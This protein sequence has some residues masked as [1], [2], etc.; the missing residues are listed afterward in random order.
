MSLKINVGC[1]DK[2]TEGWRNYDNSWSVRLAEKNFIT[3]FIIK[4]GILSESQQKFISYAK[5]ENILWANVSKNIPEKDSTVDVVYSCHMV[6]HL[7]KEDAILFLKESYRVLKMG[8]IIRVVVPNLKQQV[9]S[10]IKK[11]DADEFILSTFLTRKFP[12]SFFEKLNYILV[13][14]RN[15]Q[16]MYDGDS[17]CKL[18]S[19]SGFKNPKIVEPGTTLI[20]NPGMLDLKERY[21]ESVYVEAI[22]D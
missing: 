16:W 21:E 17:L 20:K 19:L 8:G 1:G 9:E 10:Y 5:K 15:H 13:G 14:D 22:K 12:K 6:E 7:E 3:Y 4:V 2:P 11:G 18:L